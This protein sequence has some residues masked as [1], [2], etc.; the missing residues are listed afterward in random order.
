MSLASV[1]ALES[2]L[3]DPLE[4]ELLLLGLRLLRSLGHEKFSL[5]GFDVLK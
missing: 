5:E 1:E 4:V 3:A 2:G